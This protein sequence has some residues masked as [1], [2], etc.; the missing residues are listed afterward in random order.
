MTY[1]TGNPIGSTDA[2]DRSDNSENLDLAVN[3]LSQTFVDRLGVT[4]DTLEGIYQKSAYYRAGTFD[5]GYTLTNNRQTLAYGN[6][7]YSWSGAFPKVV[8]AG[9]S[10]KTTGGV[11]AGAW[12]DRTQETLR[13]DLASEGGSGLVG[14]QPVGTGATST[15][16]QSKLRETVSV[17]DFGAVGDGS[18]ELTKLNN[19]LATGGTVVN[20]LNLTVS[21]TALIPVRGTLKSDSSKTITYTSTTD[22]G[23]ALRGYSSILGGHHKFTNFSGV[24][25]SGDQAAKIHGT[26]LENTSTSNSIAVYVNSS[27]AAYTNI[28]GNHIE[29]VDYGVLTNGS[30]TDV[31]GI[32]IVANTVIS[33]EGD[34]VELNAP[35]KNHYSIPVVGNVLA[36]IGGTSV[37]SGFAFG[38]ARARGVPFVGNAIEQSRQEAIHI[39][40][41]QHTNVVVGNTALNCGQEGIWVGSWSTG[42]AEGLPIVGN[43]FRAAIG[44]NTFAGAL[45]VY[46][47]NPAP[48]GLALI[49]NSFTNFY[50]GIVTAPKD[51]LTVGNVIK[52]ASDTALHSTGGGRLHGANLVIDTQ[53]LAKSDQASVFGKTIATTTPVT[54]L[55]TAT[56]PANTLG[57]FMK[58]FAFPKNSQTVTA[59]NTTIDLFPLPQRMKGILTC[60]VRSNGGPAEHIFF[61]ADVLYDGTTLTVSNSVKEIGGIMNVGSAAFYVV[62]SGNLAVEIYLVTETR[63]V[64][65]YVD[66]EGVYYK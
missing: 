41:E 12:V 60:T 43:N 3:S 62:N 15:T 28:L 10:P 53:T 39:E 37:N 51:V 66:F 29:A 26:R 55:D 50:R 40:D 4:R 32:P 19:A 44:N 48:E 61:S 33:S 5:A 36:S 34:A 49:G 7:E 24:N 58:G 30:A 1:N 8:P 46:D 18:N 17:K 6:V 65:I 14:Y 2:R 27:N 38:L 42:L 64:N 25:V 16:V 11:G 56:H 31:H 20:D 35:L 13:S 9:S 23:I 47:P 45:Q 22:F 54:I 21:G 59:T 52:S 63:N 57:S